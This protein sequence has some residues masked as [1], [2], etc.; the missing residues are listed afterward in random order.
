MSYKKGDYE[1]AAKFFDEAITLESTPALK[2]DYAY[3]AAA[4]SYAIK[5]YI[6]AKQYLTEALKNNPNHGDAYILLAHCY[7]ASPRWTDEAAL[8]AC[9]YFVVL[10]KL[11]RAKQ[12]D[13]SVAEKANEEIA[14][15][16]AYLPKTSDLFMIGYKNGDTINIGGWIG[17]TTRIRF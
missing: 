4:S 9:T 11:A 14:R 17:E 8:N 10:D 12:V 15:Y 13:P 2:A 6:K 16:S 3:K 5:Q 1:A 7:G